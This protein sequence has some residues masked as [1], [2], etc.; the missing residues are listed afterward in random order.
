MIRIEL[1]P[2]QAEGLLALADHTAALDERPPDI[3]GKRFNAGLRA[4]DRLRD[5]LDATPVTGLDREIDELAERL[6][7]L[8][9]A[10]ALEYFR[11]RLR[12]FLLWIEQVE[13]LG[14]IHRQA[15]A[16][17]DATRAVQARAIIERAFDGSPSWQA[18][19]LDLFDRV[20]GR[21][22]VPSVPL[23]PAELRLIGVLDQ[24][25]PPRE[26]APSTARRP[27]RGWGLLQP[28]LRPRRP[29]PEAD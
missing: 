29:V 11:M 14:D 28:A 19:A 10:R 24:L 26:A 5:A 13:R 9:D 1:S 7:G 15:V 6:G 22:P 4:V 16:A 23:S 21:E 18:D 27:P 12:D 8:R 20:E 3:H 17:G 25:R 2:A